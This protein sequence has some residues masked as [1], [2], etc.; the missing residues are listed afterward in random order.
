[1][2]RDTLRTAR[3]GV[4]FHS[5]DAAPSA[6]CPIC[7][8]DLPS[9]RAQEIFAIRGLEPG[10]YDDVIPASW[11]CCPPTRLDAQDPEMDA[12]R[13]SPRLSRMRWRMR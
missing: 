8:K 11:L 4:A 1:M 5:R 6:N 2:R 12:L 13:V 10:E 7:A 3:V 9:S